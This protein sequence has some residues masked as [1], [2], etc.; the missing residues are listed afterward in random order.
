VGWGGGGGGLVFRPVYG[1]QTESVL[2]SVVDPDPKPDEKEIICKL[3]SGS[4]IKFGSESG[5]VSGLS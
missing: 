5:F 1:V 3:G 2:S 4:V